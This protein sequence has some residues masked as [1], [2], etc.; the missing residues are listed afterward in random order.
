MWTFIVGAV[1][2]VGGMLASLA[3]A[4]IKWMAVLFAFRLG[5]RKAQQEA[6]EDVAEIR[7]E[8]IEILSKPDAHRDTLLKRMLKRKRD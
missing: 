8:Q 7:D 4:L 3:N 2:K 5:K 1:A 6:Q